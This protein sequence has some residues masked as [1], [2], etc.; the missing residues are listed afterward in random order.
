MVNSSGRH[1]EASSG[2][3]CLALVTSYM[4]REVYILGGGATATFSLNT[5]L[6]A[7]S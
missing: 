7:M 3:F 5:R 4:Q 2:C 1:L 6:Y